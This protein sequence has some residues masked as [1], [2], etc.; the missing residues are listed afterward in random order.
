MH[1]LDYKIAFN[2]VVRIEATGVRK[3]TRRS[4]VSVN[5]R[6]AWYVDTEYSVLIK[7]QKLYFVDTCTK[8]FC[9]F[10]MHRLFSLGKSSTV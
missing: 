6:K 1:K 10:S 2:F 9:D 8:K 7:L 3:Q 5:V 4:I